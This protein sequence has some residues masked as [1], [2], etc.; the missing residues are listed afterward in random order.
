M[1][2]PEPLKT[3][4]RSQRFP[5][6]QRR[7]PSGHE[8]YYHFFEPQAGSYRLT[9]IE[10]H[11]LA[12]TAGDFQV[13]LTWSKPEALV[14][15]VTA[16]TILADNETISWLAESGEEVRFW[17]TEMAF[18]LNLAQKK[19]EL[20]ISSWVG[21]RHALRVLFFYGFLEN[22]GILL[23]ASGVV[24]GGQAFVFPGPSGAGKTTIVRHSPDGVI[25]S[26][27]VVAVRLASSSGVLLAQGTPFF[28]DWGRPGEK[29]VAVAKGLYF[30]RHSSE[31]RLV[32]L[33]PPQI[34]ARLLPC[35][36]IYTESKERLGKLFDLA[37]QIA[38]SVKG[39]DLHFRPGQDFWQIVNHS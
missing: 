36:F 27:E 39:F 25:L 35:I 29:M 11:R 4:D 8:N 15:P 23:H 28:G 22:Q 12:L 9:I 20:Q 24:K 37:A 1:N 26:D 3:K 6:D 30:P 19:G 31:N 18:R 17:T 38:G 34:L 16:R 33:T 21:W 14:P 7:I 10:P 32:S 5:W 2:N 13:S